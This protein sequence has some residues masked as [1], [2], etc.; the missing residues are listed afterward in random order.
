LSRGYNDFV[1]CFQIKHICVQQDL[2]I[3]MLNIFITKL[4]AV[5]SITQLLVLYELVW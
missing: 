5:F 4:Y 1:N 2:H 3:Y